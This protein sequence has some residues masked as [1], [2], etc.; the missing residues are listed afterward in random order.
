MGDGSEWQSG[1]ESTLGA[2]CDEG[3]HPNGVNNA[4]EAWAMRRWISD[5]AGDVTVV[6]HLRKANGANSG[7]TGKMILNGNEIFSQVVP[8]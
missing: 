8:E 6:F 4:F 7:I 5:Y 1:G 2:D 3:V